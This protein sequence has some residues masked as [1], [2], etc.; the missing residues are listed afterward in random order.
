MNIAGFAGLILLIM[1]GALPL[2]KGIKRRTRT[3]MW[4]ARTAIL[5]VL[6]HAAFAFYF[7]L[8]L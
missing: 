5:V 4:L 8:G 1:T 6:I 2:I 7:L 3:H